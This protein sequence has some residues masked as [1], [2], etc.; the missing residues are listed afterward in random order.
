[1]YSPGS[2]SAPRFDLTSPPIL[3]GTDVR[4]TWRPVNDSGG[5]PDN[6]YYDVYTVQLTGNSFEYCRQN[7]EDIDDGI[8][9][10]ACVNVDVCA[11][12]HV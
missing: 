5:D 6:L 11:H 9:L 12:V 1:M 3:D 2:P 4:L 8:G 7:D 10:C